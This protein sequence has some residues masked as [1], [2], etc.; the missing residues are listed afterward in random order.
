MCLLRQ[1]GLVRLERHED[2][3]AS[4]Q[5]R[6]GRQRFLLRWREGDVLLQQGRQILH[7]RR[8]GGGRLLQRLRQGQDCLIML[9]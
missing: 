4:R 3:R 9:R 5:A 2:V 7:E 6:E 1:D 8:Q